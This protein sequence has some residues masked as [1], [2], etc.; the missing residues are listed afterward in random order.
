MAGSVAAATVGT[1][2]RDGGTFRVFLCSASAVTCFDSIDPALAASFGGFAVGQTT[3]ASLVRY[4][5]KPPPAGY[6]L[7]PELAVNYPRISNRGRTYVFRIRK[8]RRYSTGGLV[9]GR[10]FAHAL[11]RILDPSVK[12]PLAPSFARVV[13]AA[14]VLAGRAKTAAGVSATRSSVTFRLTQADGAFLSNLTGLCAVPEALPADPEGARAPLPSAGPYY[15]SDY[16]PGKRIV[17]ER[18]PHYRGGRPHHV[19]RFD[20][21]LQASGPDAIIEQVK[22]GKADWGWVSTNS[23]GP[24][25]ADLAK[26]YGVNRTRFFVHRGLFLRLFVLNTSRP[27]FRNNAPLRRAVNF[28]VDRAALSA[29]R[30]PYTGRP[31]D[32]FLSPDY[33]GYRHVRIYPMKPNLA[34]ARALARGHTG[35]GKAVVYVPDNPIPIAQAQILQTDLKQIGLELT[36]KR[37]PVSILF[38]KLETPGEPF[39]LGW[40]GWTG[41]PDPFLLD[42]LFNG[43]WIRPLAEGGCNRSYFNSPRYN[44]LLNTASRLAGTARRRAFGRLDVE[45]ARD[46]APAIAYAYDNALTLVSSRTGC[47]VLNPT[48]DLTAV[49]LKS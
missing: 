14:D 48:L 46:A 12:S 25:A 39:D 28:A 42:C 33:P 3:C 49:C 15:V 47:V 17:L 26:R 34:R 11:D 31:I 30:G 41:N 43:K 8:G 29:Q 5:D 40:I 38:E 21:D 45:L 1:A 24:S 4:P 27:L 22:A 35:E 19:A 6:R 32:H 36:I 44:R 16:V 9:G 20:V 7:V 37:F 2:P 13:G 18:N 10:D 23:F